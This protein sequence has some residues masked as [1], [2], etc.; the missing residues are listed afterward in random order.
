MRVLSDP[1]IFSFIILSLYAAQ[2]VRWG[3]ERKWW[4]VLYW[5]GAFIITTSVTFDKQ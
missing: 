2:A 1:R 5:V 3:M 4:S